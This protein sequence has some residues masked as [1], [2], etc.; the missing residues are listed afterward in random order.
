M[1]L[2][3][4]LMLET[5]K[6]QVGI[7]FVLLLIFVSQKFISI[8]AKAISGVIPPDLVLTLLYL[9][10]PTLGTLMLP[11]SFYLAVLFAHGRLHGESEM[12]AM[13]S[14]GYSPNSVLKATLVLSVFTFAFA[15]F[16]S[17][18]LAPLA[19]DKMISVIEN[20]ESDAGAATLIEGRFHKTSGQGGVVYVE[21]YK[22]GQK[23]ERVFAAHWPTDKNKAPSVLTSLTGSVE[24]KKD[25][26]W[27]TLYDGQRYAGIVGQS[28]FDS[29]EFD[30]FEVHIANR[31]VRERKRGVEALPTAQLFGVATPAYQ[32]ELQWRF[33]IPLS[34]LMITFLAVPMA[35]VNPRQGR[36]AK[37]L[38]ALSLY[39]TFFLLLS[40][41]RSLI[42][43]GTMP[44]FS[45]WGVLLLF[46]AFGVFLHLQ[47][48][49]KFSSAKRKKKI[50]V[51]S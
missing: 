40:T 18:Y 12:I 25:G 31:E 43:E 1:I 5:F 48:L 2:R 41:S 24:N 20:A 39:L 13:T 35:K 44:A 7:L 16:N 30:R 21:K 29:S 45:I 14:C 32:A 47:T 49:G 9:N 42:E 51:E 11:I 22:E 4:Y 46:L 3:R 26:T 6:S 36:Y 15:S 38:P 19:E 8:L 50:K 10:L 37:L 17:L 23:L 33:A 27:L 28:Q 34:I